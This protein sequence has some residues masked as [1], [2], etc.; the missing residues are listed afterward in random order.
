LELRALSRE[1]G[2]DQQAHAELGQDEEDNEGVVRVLRA[3]GLA[4]GGK[5]VGR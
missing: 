1:L 4:V 2:A 5:Q 3:Q